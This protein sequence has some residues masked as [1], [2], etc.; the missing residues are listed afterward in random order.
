M[1]PS[2][3]TKI[4][5]IILTG[6]IMAL[7]LALFK[8]LPMYLYGENILFDASMHVTLTFFILY[9]LW[10]FI[11]QN[12][13]LRIPFFIFSAT[14]LIIISIQRIFVRA[15]DEWGILL[16]FVISLLAI[17]ISERKSLKEKFEF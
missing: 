7:G 15:H 10:F 9:I 17:Y 6:G 11:N 8:Y 14:L 5:K 2:K 12:K 3:R 13:K 1:N 4:K 16:G